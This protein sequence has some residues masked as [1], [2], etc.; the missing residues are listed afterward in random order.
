MPGF[1]NDKTDHV[2]YKLLSEIDDCLDRGVLIP[3][4]SMSLLIPDIC[5]SILYPKS[6]SVKFRYIAWYDEYQGKYDSYFDDVHKR[7][8]FDEYVEALHV[9][10]DG[11][12]DYGKKK[13]ISAVDAVLKW[14]VGYGVPEFC[15]LFGDAVYALRCSFLHTGS[16]KSFDYDARYSFDFVTGQ[17]I[18][19]GHPVFVDFVEEVSD[20]EIRYHINIH[21][22]CKC[23][24]RNGL[25]FFLEH[26]NEFGNM[27]F[28]VTDANYKLWMMGLN[29]LGGTLHRLY[30][31]FDEDCD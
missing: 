14:P 18:R 21:R 13:Q 5:G 4:L 25:A 2:F 1:H 3:A 11:F 15:G 10:Y 24:I 22:L 12:C 29:P 28:D 27:P 26:F 31:L 7:E 17:V 19:D 9:A 16:M 30:S 8:L 20:K 6:K 23:L